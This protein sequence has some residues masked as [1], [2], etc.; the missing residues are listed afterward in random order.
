MRLAIQRVRKAEVSVDGQSVGKIGLGL[1][2]LIGV[3]QG[4]KLEKADELANK[5]VNMRIMADQE[6]K[7]NL[8]VKDVGGEVLVVSQF[9]LYG[10]ATNGRRPSFIKAA[11]PNLAKEIYERIIEK[12][13]ENGIK[14][15]TGNFGAYMKINA[16]LDGPVT[17]IIES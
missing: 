8:S 1:F 13:R 5:L 14:V 3:G 15:E 16:E 9:T 12:V 11:E 7:M 4:D 2:V 10:D 17:I 6:D